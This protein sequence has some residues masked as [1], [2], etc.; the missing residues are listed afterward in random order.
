MKVTR[1]GPAVSYAQHFLLATREN[2][3]NIVKRKQTL[4]PFFE[5]LHR[6]YCH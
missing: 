6:L 4:K 5:F 3:A 2:F 1:R